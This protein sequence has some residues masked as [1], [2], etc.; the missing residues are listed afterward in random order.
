VPGKQPECAEKDLK[1]RKNRFGITKHLFRII[2]KGRITDLV[3]LAMETSKDSFALFNNPLIKF[4]ASPRLRWLRHALFIMVGLL[5]AF[6][7]DVGV[8]D[9]FGSKEALRAMWIIDS[10][11]FVFL[12]GMIY[13]MI[14]VLIPRLLFRSKIFAFGISFFIILTIIYL[15]VWYLDTNYLRPVIPL[16]SGF[17]HVE[18]SFISFIQLAAVSTVLL[19]SVVGMVVF[20]KWVNDIQLMNELQQTNL[21]TELEQ[22]KS[23]VNPHF[24]FNTLNN[25]LVLVKTDAEKASQV[26]L[27]LSDL[28]RYQ[29]YD[30][31]KEKILLS[32]DIDFIHNLLALEKIRKVDFEYTINTSG[33]TD[34]VLLPPFL[35]IPFVENAIKHGASTVGHSYLKV[36]FTITDKQLSFSSENSR[37]PVK[38]KEIGGLGLS[39]LKRRLELLYPGTHRMHVQDEPDKYIVNLTIPV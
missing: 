12:M 14:L 22:L 11:T 34:G 29:L 18:L 32:K 2:W 21:K 30:S 9:R 28:L 27:G 19:G 13:L 1:S 4:I 7:G 33:R 26:L 10:I 39:N 24:L 6:K 31:A 35:F 23:Q 38:K 8:V 16:E 25:L 3:D 20:K 17:E 36:D 15:V 37:S 5:L